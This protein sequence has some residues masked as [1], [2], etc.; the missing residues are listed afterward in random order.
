MNQDTGNQAVADFAKRDIALEF[1]CAHLD[2][3][4]EVGDRFK[5]ITANHARIDL[6]VNV[7]GGSFYRHKFEEFPL[8]HWKTII[9]AN[10]TSTFLCCR[11][12]TLLMKNQKAGAIVNISSDIA[13]SG[14]ENRS[15]E[16]RVGKECRL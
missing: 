9:D 5:K 6:L 7:A 13:Y 16:R 4:A 14:G 11:A 1:H 8:D 3:E 15:E 2:N 12:V 10:L